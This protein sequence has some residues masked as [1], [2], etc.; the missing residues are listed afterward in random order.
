MNTGLILSKSEEQKL[1]NALDHLAIDIRSIYGTSAKRQANKAGFALGRI[2]RRITAAARRDGYHDVR[3]GDISYADRRVECTIQG[4][5]ID[6]HLEWSAVLLATYHDLDA[7]RGINWRYAGTV[8][9][10]ITYH[11]TYA[12]QFLRAVRARYAPTVQ[13]IRDAESKRTVALEPECSR[14]D[15]HQ[16][17]LHGWRGRPA[18]AT[19]DR[20]G[21]DAPR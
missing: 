20:T 10:P 9:T 3:T 16:W 7:R 4:F 18:A 12:R 17:R 15:G 21:L 8:G 5:G 11:R 2:V 13:R 1:V 14:M 19:A 6:G